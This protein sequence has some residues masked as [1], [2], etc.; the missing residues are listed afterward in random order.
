MYGCMDV[1]W[2][3]CIE[4]AHPNTAPISFPSFS[5]SVLF[6]NYHMG[7]E[8]LLPQDWRSPPKKFT[9]PGG[10]FWIWHNNWYLGIWGGNLM[11]STKIKAV[12][13]LHAN[14]GRPPLN[15]TSESLGVSICLHLQNGNIFHN[16][17][18]GVVLLGYVSLGGFRRWKRRRWRKLLRSLLVLKVLVNLF[19]M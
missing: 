18:I 4:Q 12:E 11:A 1:L 7:Q 3:S 13:R 16:K 6:S 15:V 17:E 2:V 10:L 19:T 9:F 8:K 14:A 5:P